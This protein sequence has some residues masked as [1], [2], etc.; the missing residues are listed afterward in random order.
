[1]KLSN[2][3]DRQMSIDEQ[4]VEKVGVEIIETSQKRQEH[5]R[6]ISR[7]SDGVNNQTSRCDN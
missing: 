1:M 5:R 6:R 3:H 7:S 2:T 4:N